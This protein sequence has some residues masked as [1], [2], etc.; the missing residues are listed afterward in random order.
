[1]KPVISNRSLVSLRGLRVRRSSFL[2]PTDFI[3][4][5]VRAVCTSRTNRPHT[6]TT[7][8]GK[9][10]YT[11]SPL[12]TPLR[13]HPFRFFHISKHYLWPRAAA[14]ADACLPLQ[15]LRACCAARVLSRNNS[16]AFI[17]Y[18]RRNCSEIN[19]HRHRHEYALCWSGELLRAPTRLTSSG[20]ILC[21]YCCHRRHCCDVSGRLRLAH[22]QTNDVCVWC[23]VCDIHRPTQS[24]ARFSELACVRPPSIDAAS[25]S[26]VSLERVVAGALRLMFM[27][28]FGPVAR[29]P[30]C[31]ASISTI[32]IAPSHIAA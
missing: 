32:I 7:E 14:A 18:K 19:V 28:T 21:Y 5:P 15:I 30:T 16:G 26:S 9:H 29:A 12:S 10:T 25:L 4:P 3:D 11:L 24:V 20:R 17:S 23:N 2:G 27:F 13:L 31:A 8:S 6:H 22:G 1:M